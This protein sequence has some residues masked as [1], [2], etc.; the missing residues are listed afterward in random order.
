MNP[1][2]WDVRCKYNKEIKLNVSRGHFA[3]SHA[4]VDHYMSLTG[5]RTHQH[6]ARLSAQELAKYYMMTAPVDTIICLEY[7]Q[8]IGSY[9][10]ME[11][12]QSGNRSINENRDICVI[13]PEINSNSQLVFTSEIQYLV[14]DKRIL[15][16]I[17]TIST[18]RSLNRA[19][20]CISYYGGQLVGVAALFSAVK[21]AAGVPI[22]SLFSPDD[23]PDY[24]SYQ[25]SECPLCQRGRKLD[26]L[27]TMSGY[28]RI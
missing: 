9:L 18:G 17:S 21:S 19:L 22:H 12:A 7:T 23:V 10:A 27:V 15:V 11:L 25:S 14:Q 20:E 26:G 5:I 28:T 16:L 6:M 3:T 24:H 8:V 13:T 4:H 2:S 1:N